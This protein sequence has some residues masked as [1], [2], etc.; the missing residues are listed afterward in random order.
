LREN[1]LAALRSAAHS[2]SHEAQWMWAKY[3]GDNDGCRELSLIWTCRAA[4]GGVVAAQY[5]MAEH[6]WQS[7][8]KAAFLEWSLP[9]ARDLQQFALR[10]QKQGDISPPMFSSE[11]LTL[12][13]RCGQVLLEQSDANA[14]D[15]QTFWEIAATGGA[16]DAQFSLG[17]LLAGMRADGEKDFIE[18]RQI[19]YAKAIHWLTLAGDQGLK[20]A[21]F[22][23]SR[24]HERRFFS[25][26]DLGLARHY[27]HRAAEMGHCQAQYECGVSAWD[28]RDVKSTNES[29]AIYWLELAEAQGCIAAGEM[30]VCI[31][32]ALVDEPGTAQLA[33]GKGERILFVA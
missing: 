12:L 25:G 24:I 21:W 30:L 16:I 28:F 8:D 33:A 20:E 11:Q 3:V 9:L 31:R 32:K 26:K 15:V 4:K 13:Q 19:D 18:S 1:A 27:R 17:L 29:R 22:V 14:G 7:G 6:V 5:V 23:L 10:W 2:G